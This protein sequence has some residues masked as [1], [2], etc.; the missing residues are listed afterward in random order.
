MVRPMRPVLILF[1]VD[2]TLVDTAG[3]GRRGIEQ[4]FTSVFGTAEIA[5][6]SARVRFDGKTDPVIIAE[7][8]R[9][10]GIPEAELL[11]RRNDL[12]R[13]YLAALRD[14][15]AR[16]DPRRRALP[17]VRA[18]LDDLAARDDV[19]LGLLTGNTEAGA[20][21]KLDALALG[22]Y[23]ENGG[24]GSDDPDRVSIARLARE[25]MSWHASVAFEA[26]RTT[27]VGD[28]ELDVACALANGFRAVA[29]ASGSVAIERLATSGAHAVLPDLADL[30]AALRALGLAGPRA[31]S[32]LR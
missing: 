32:G 3:C 1:D 10:A 31:A 19:H 7:I 21:L 18:L 20:R 15:L 27:V 12:D 17:G 6:V 13:A 25:K 29:V 24:F 5:V 11:A 26:S 23:F 30:G 2:G 16:P 9:E 22:S 8:A 14:A 28:T 4:A